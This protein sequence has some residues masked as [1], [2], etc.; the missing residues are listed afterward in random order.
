[1]LADETQ[2]VSVVPLAS[3]K[4]IS[5]ESFS[6]FSTETGRPRFTTAMTANFAC[7]S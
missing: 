1:M 4:R 5:D 3:R 2:P 6:V 7:D